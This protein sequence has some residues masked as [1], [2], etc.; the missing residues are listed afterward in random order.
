MLQASRT[1]MLEAMLELNIP[2][3]LS[4]FSKIGDQYVLF[5]ALMASS[6]FDEVA[7]EVVTLAE[8]SVEAITA[9]TDYLK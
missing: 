7:H 8:N 1:D 9:L 2:I 5:G 6:S 4:A 3:P